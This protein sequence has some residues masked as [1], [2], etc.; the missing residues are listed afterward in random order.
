M[1][2]AVTGAVAVSLATLYRAAFNQQRQ[3][4][5]EIAQSQAR[6]LSAIAEYD[7]TQGSP[8]DVFR[9]LLDQ[10]QTTPERFQGFGNT[11][12]LT[13]ATQQND[14]IVFLLSYRNHGIA[15]PS[16]VP[17]ASDLAEPTRRALSGESGTIIGTDYRGQQVLAA[18]EPIEQLGLGLV[19]K[20]D[21]TELR[22]P[23]IEAGVRAATVGL[24]FIGVAAFLFLR[25]GN[26]LIEQIQ[27]SHAA[28][29]EGARQI[30]ET[31]VQLREEIRQRQ[32]A[33]EAL[34]ESEERYRLLVEQSP[35]AIGLHVDGKLIFANSA[36]VRLVGAATPA[37]L[38]GRSI[39]DFVHPEDR[40]Q[41]EDRWRH[42]S[43][44]ELVPPAQIRALTLDGRVI[45]AETVAAP[46][47]Y[48]GK[49]A[50]QFVARDVTEQ[51]RLEQQLQQAQ[52][53]E[54]IGRLAGGVAHDF[55]N[56][57]F[58]ISGY[59]ELLSQQ[60]KGES[61]AQ[62]AIEEIRR[63]AERAGTLTRQLLA[64][65][66]KQVLEL[67]VIDLNKELSTMQDMLGRVV[68][69]DVKLEMRLHPDVRRARF[70][71]G[72][73]H[74]VVLNLVINARD[75]MPEGGRLTIETANVELDDAYARSHAEVSAGLYVMLSVSDTGV[76]MGQET[77]PKIFEPFFT[78]KEAGKG[79]GL[80]LPTVH[81]IVK[82]CG[83]H[84][85]VYSEPG[86]GTTFNVYLPATNERSQDVVVVP[87]ESYETALGAEC[88]LLVE[89]EP[90]VRDLMESALKAN[91]Y[92]VFVAEDGNRALQLANEHGGKI[93]LLITD[94]V[95]PDVP[96]RALAERICSKLP[97]TKV[98]YMSGYA[99]NAVVTHGKLEEGLHFIQKPC[100]INALLTKIRLVLGQ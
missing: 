63:A 99:E 26:P 43:R 33:E 29:I 70:D 8:R 55:N 17:A 51:R 60:L 88:I 77:L 44:G 52:K 79:T 59:A 31:N 50:V 95:M 62:R 86:T 73:L 90:S 72:Q 3:R 16:P 84:I 21:V 89:D 34:R 97:N 10:I 7:A 37:D 78:T 68:G 27:Q 23:F 94:L 81:G 67:R 39:T 35:D 71:P 11:G 49:P 25:V 48:R 9:I 36:M 100:S 96:G 40:A 13:L 58:V 56:H 15:H 98:L 92:T 14:Q 85:S 18:Y 69:E 65:S 1:T 41:I 28:L 19:A 24:F 54:A 83:G 76:G 38:V 53:M 32:Q 45:H 66:R 47:P 6:L 22:A 30:E 5:L 80:G 91:G 46:L 57:L 87:D 20:I 82:Q 64:V 2:V 12:E 74:Q 93:D 61:T 75:A 42:L 4:L